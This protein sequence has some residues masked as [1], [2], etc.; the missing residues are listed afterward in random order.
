MFSKLIG[1]EI[2]RKEDPRLITGKGIYTGDLKLPGLKHVMFVRSPY[3]HARIRSIDTAAALKLPGVVAIVTADELQPNY[4]RLP[5]SGDADFK[6]RR[7]RYPLAVDIVRC[8]GEAVAVVIANSPQQAEDAAVAVEVDWEPLPATG[9][10][11]QALQSPPLY[12]DM[13]GPADMGDV[14][15]KGDVTAAFASA[16]RTVKQRIHSQRLAAIPMEPRAVIAAPDPASS[17]LTLWSS[18]QTPHNVRSEL[19]A[20]LDLPENMIRVIAPDVG[21][22]FGVKIGV[23]SEEA[24]LA[25]LALRLQLPLRWIE[26]RMENILVTT[27]GRAQMADIELALQQDGKITGLKIRV[28]ND[29]GAY[30]VA[31]WLPWLTGYMSVGVYDIPAV[32]IQTGYTHTNTTPISAYRGAGRPEAAYYIERM[33]DLAA[34][35]L[36]LDP[37]VVRRKNFIQPHQFPYEAASGPTYDSGDYDKVL[38][39]ALE[40]ANYNDLRAEQASRPA[41]HPLLLGIGTACF[42]ETCA[43]GPYESA[44]VRVEPTGTVTVYTGI[45]PHGQGNAT[46]FAQI[47]ADAIGADFDRIVVKYGDTASTPMGIGT[48]GSRGLAVGGMAVVQAAATVKAKAQQIAAHMLEAAVEDIVLE[49]GQYRVRGVP[50]TGLTLQEI[51]DRAYSDNLPDD[52][53]SGLEATDFFRPAASLY[54]FGAHVAVV[55]I[56]RETGIVHLRDYVSVDDCGRRISPVLVEGQVHGGLAQG[57]GQALLEEIIYDEYG[58]L[59]SGTLM[60]YAIPRADTFPHFRTALSETPTPHNLL[61]A[62]GVGELGTIGATPTVVNAVLDALKPFGIRH[63][64]MPLRP[65]KIWRAM[66]DAG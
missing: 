15:R 8:A 3:A 29:S 65:E 14:K 63:L 33:V 48:Y 32:E 45:M 28:V 18:T 60:D 37:V 38:T 40:L 64:D 2:K 56:E 54:P 53:S 27:H 50:S 7:S 20:S 23:Y 41:D 11:E 21:G 34:H 13:E 9:S 55:E 39:M 51:A 42:V 1:A 57:I 26:T 30:P 52:I 44:V 62:K 24:V 19:A 36:G 31:T 17:G 12:A 35:E 46:T 47:V 25:L 5:V 4:G 58:Q 10:I 22:G 43:P 59:L 49:E 6:A 16:F 66:N 61:G